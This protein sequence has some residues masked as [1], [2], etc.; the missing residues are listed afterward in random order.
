MLLTIQIV[1]YN[2]RENLAKCL[3]SV[4][5]NI[6]SGSSLQVI[7]INNESESIGDN[8]NSFPDVEAIEGK[9]NLGFGRAHNLG[10]RKARGK[11][12]LFLN[13]DTRILPDTIAEL[14]RVFDS[15]EKIGVAG[16][17]LVGES[18]DVE[19]EHYGFRK[20]LFS[21]VG[22][23]L[24]RNGGKFAKLMEVDWISGGAMM[25]RK[26]LFS[27]MGGFDEK[28]F[29]YFEDVDLC[30]QAK[31]RGYRVVVDP[32][33]RIFHKGG[34]SFSDERLKKKYYYASQDYYI[35]KNFGSWQAGLVKILRF[36]FYVKNVY[37]SK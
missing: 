9:E 15:D 5:E 19:E 7:V 30:L 3:D 31:K 29:M 20:T 26:D 8:L 6:P 27:E 1:N 12:I 35:R 4:Y 34:Q 13:P 11:Y 37:F 22:S 28:F 21:L 16:P 18:G 36:P 23:K 25:I 14:V 32:K 33:A 10:A 17:L 2:S 24:F